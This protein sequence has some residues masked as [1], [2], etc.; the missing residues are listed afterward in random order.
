MWNP[1]KKSQKI[2]TPKCATILYS[3]NLVALVIAFLSDAPKLLALEHSPLEELGEGG[4]KYGYTG[5]LRLDIH[6]GGLTNPLV[7]R[8]MRQTFPQFVEI[9]E[10]CDKVEA[11]VRRYDADFF[12]NIERGYK[13]DVE[14]RTKVAR[15]S[16]IAKFFPVDDLE[17]IVA[18]DCFW[19]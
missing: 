12:E 13:N 4:V 2:R 10:I 11:T 7:L 15:H 9:G 16:Y 18:P 17:K 6:N 8:Y 19:R 1:F 14:H 5:Y 3:E